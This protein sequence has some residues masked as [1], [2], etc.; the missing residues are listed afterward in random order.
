MSGEVWELDQ[1]A[2]R[3][4]GGP[5]AG[6]VGRGVCEAV[7]ERHAAAR[8]PTKT[9]KEL[10]TLE[11]VALTNERKGTGDAPTTDAVLLTSSP[12]TPF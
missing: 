6:A 9:K 2:W 4:V 10:E 7:H 5:S 8:G 11:K 12:P 1:R 3:R